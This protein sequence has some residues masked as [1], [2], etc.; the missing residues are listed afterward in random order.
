VNSDLLHSRAIGP[1]R[2][3]AG[4]SLHRVT[5]WSVGNE[6]HEGN[7]SEPE[8]FMDAQLEL[9]FKPRGILFV[10]W[11]ETAGFE[12]N[13]SLQLSPQSALKPGSLA[14]WPASHLA[15]WR[16]LVG[17]DLE[18]FQV[19]GDGKTPYALNLE[20]TTGSVALSSGYRGNPGSG[21]DVQVRPLAPAADETA[22]H[23]PGSAITKMDT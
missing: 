18:G 10:T 22:C 2:Q 19:L 7:L 1:L 15:V 13:F 5:D 21:E 12:D 17:S 11:E 16:H 14:R 6:F 9:H 4:S 3:V 8:F 23:A 20:F